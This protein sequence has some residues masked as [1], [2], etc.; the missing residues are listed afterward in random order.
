MPGAQLQA[1]A[2]PLAAEQLEQMVAPIA[3]YPDTLVAQILAAA[4]YPAQVVDA[5]HWLQAQG[6]APP[7]QIAAKP[8]RRRGIRA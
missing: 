4:T 1:P 2:Q 7:E 5:D 6:N 3:L 8:T